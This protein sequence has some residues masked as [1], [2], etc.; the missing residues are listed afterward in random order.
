M[1]CSR[2]LLLAA[3][4]RTSTEIV[5]GTADALELPL[6]EDPE[7]LG[8]QLQRQVSDLVEEERSSVCQ[9]EPALSAGSARP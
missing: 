8:L 6:L 7:E 4:T 2:F 3:I 9:L 1:A 5:S